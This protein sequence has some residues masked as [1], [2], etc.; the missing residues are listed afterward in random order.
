MEIKFLMRNLNQL[1]VYFMSSDILFIYLL[2]Y[3]FYFASVHSILKKNG[4]ETCGL[5][6]LPCKYWI[7]QV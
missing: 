5:I 4:T 7:P 3:L 6:M 1:R 2:F